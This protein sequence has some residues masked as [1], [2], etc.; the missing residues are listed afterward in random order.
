VEL[1]TERLVLRPWRPDD[2]EPFAALN[3]DPEVMQHFPST[4]TREQSDAFAERVEAHF[5]EHGYGLWAVEV[6]GHFAGFDGL[7]WTDALG[8]R[9][10]EVGWRLARWAWGH[11]YATE[12]ARAA[13]EVGL[14]HAP[15]VVSF[16]ALV[17]ERSWRVME[18]LGMRRVREFEH[19][20]VP[21][22]SP[23]RRH[24]LYATP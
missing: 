23:L 20:R 19:P 6:D 13:L 8:G 14:Q 7:Q 22:G 21:E 9:D 18:R 11:G 24:V 5:A 15:E 16:T 1:R 12:A 4:L 10:L 17:N 3:A 2:R